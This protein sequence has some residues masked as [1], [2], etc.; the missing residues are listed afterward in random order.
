[1]A[2]VLGMSTI[3][4]EAFAGR[5]IAGFNARATISMTWQAAIER[6]SASLRERVAQSLAQAARR[7]NA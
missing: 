5:R 6:C 3:V 4:E 1:M 2:A 7:Y